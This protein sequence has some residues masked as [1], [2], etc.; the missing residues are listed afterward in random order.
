MKPY[1]EKQNKEAQD[2]LNER[3]KELKQEY[4]N[5]KNK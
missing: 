3:N 2:V 4:L 1:F 5:S